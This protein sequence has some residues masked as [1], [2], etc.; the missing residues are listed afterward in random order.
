MLRVSRAGR[1]AGRS[2]S[3]TQAE[4]ARLSASELN[5]AGLP[6]T[7]ADVETVASGSLSGADDIVYL[8][9]LDEGPDADPTSGLS[10][11]VGFVQAM[12]R[13]RTA[14]KLW[15]VTRGSQRARPGDCPLGCPR[16]SLGRLLK[17]LPIEM[18]R[19]WGGLIDVESGT[20]ATAA[21]RHLARVLT[22]DAGED[23]LAI[24]DGRLHVAR[25]TR[26]DVPRSAPRS[27]RANATYLVTGGL[28][29][30]GLEAA[31][32][33]ARRGA[34]HL[35]L[36]GRAPAAQRRTLDV[37][38]E[39]ERDGVDTRTATVDVANREVLENLR[40]A[41]AT[42]DVLRFA[43]SCTR[44]ALE[45]PGARRSLTRGVRT[46]SGTESRRHTGARRGVP[47]ARSVHR[48]LRVFSAAAGRDA[49]Q[50]CGGERVPRRLPPLAWRRPAGLDER[51]LGDSV[52]GRRFCHHRVW[53]ARA[54]A[55]R[56]AWHY[57]DRAT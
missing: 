24:R 41:N 51:Q 7:L 11:A 34:R 38:R 52:G 3:E 10:H 1:I 4:W 43:V 29:G 18:P 6:S 55:A 23:Q 2:S 12:A 26:I 30:L 31:R 49:R 15:F 40:T 20:P 39:L 28:R 56:V 48:V 17:V 32:W 5:A 8:K 36:L 21:A 46:G 44:P 57:P 13:A 33:L 47:V 9:H 25:L 42:A 16:R 53:G 35:V 50:L 19:Q 22:A 45:R 37:L 14:A 54:R 27:L